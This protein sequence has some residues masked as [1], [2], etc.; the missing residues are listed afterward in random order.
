MTTQYTSLLGLAL[1]VTG[2]LSGTWGD[3][4][5]D[6]ITQLVEDSIANYATASVTSGDWTLS[7]TGSGAANEARMMILRPT[8]TPGVSRN[9]IAPSKSKVYVVQNDSNAAVVLKGLA[10][11]GTTIPSGA[12]A[13]CAWDGTDFI[14]ISDVLGPSSSTNNAIATYNGTTGKVIQNTGVTIDGS[15]NVTIPGQGDLRW[16]D[17]DSSN[18]V[19][20]QAPA[21]VATNVTWTLPN[22]DGTSSQVLTTNGSG[23]LSWSTPSGGITTGKSIAMALIFGF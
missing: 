18:W 5:N 22:A 12:Q 23:T 10:T 21:T 17:S 15:N 16:A 3:V 7:T 13:L 6:S 8:G 1:P 9:I 2:E 14:T 4:V 11:S 19:A 20:F